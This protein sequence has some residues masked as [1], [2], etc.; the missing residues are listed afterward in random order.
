M[1]PNDWPEPFPPKNSTFSSE[2]IWK[3]ILSF[4][5]TLARD[6]HQVSQAPGKS[7]IEFLD[8]R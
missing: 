1:R 4:G 8:R 5:Q 2:E 3:K 6:G 7:R